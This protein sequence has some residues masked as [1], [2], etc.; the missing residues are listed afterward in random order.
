M[1]AGGDRVFDVGRV[2]QRR[3]G[4]AGLRLFRV[5]NDQILESAIP[6]LQV[7]ELAAHF[8]SKTWSKVADGLVYRS[9]HCKP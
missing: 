5:L 3:S 1:L 9:R 4:T 2:G 6:A 8:Q 7:T